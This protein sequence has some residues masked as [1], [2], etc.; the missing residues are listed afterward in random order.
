VRRNTHLLS[1]IP[2]VSGLAGIIEKDNERI[3]QPVQPDSQVSFKRKDSGTPALNQQ[4]KEF[5]DLFNEL[6]RHFSDSEM[7]QVMEILD[8]LSQD[9]S[10]LTSVLELV[11][12][13]EEK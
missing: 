3:G 6:Q 4:E 9:K 7:G 1:Q 2:A 10:I 12:D 5:V 11:K 8:A 13:E